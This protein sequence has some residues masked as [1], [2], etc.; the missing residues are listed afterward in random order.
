MA[1]DTHDLV[2]FHWPL[3]ADFRRLMAR[4]AALSAAAV[5]RMRLEHMIDDSR[6]KFHLDAVGYVCF[7]LTP[8]PAQ[9]GSTPERRSGA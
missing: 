4:F 6:R 5:V 9:N 7:A 1:P 2:V 8:G 3:Y